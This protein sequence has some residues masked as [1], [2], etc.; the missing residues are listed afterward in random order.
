LRIADRIAA[1]AS[2][3]VRVL[4]ACSLARIEG[5]ATPKIRRNPTAFALEPEREALLRNMSGNGQATHDRELLHPED[6]RRW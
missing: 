3:S 1:A 2:F 4:T 6:A 5:G